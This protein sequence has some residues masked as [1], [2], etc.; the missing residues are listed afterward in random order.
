MN[1]TRSFCLHVATSVV[2]IVSALGWAAPAIASSPVGLYKWIVE[3][4]TTAEPG[5]L[6]Y[7][8]SKLSPVVKATI[9]YHLDA[10]DA[11]RKNYENLW[12]GQGKPIGMD[13]QASLPTFDGEYVAIRITPANKAVVATP[14]ENRVRANAVLRIWFDIAANNGFLGPIFVPLDSFNSIVAAF[15]N[16]KF[17]PKPLGA[18]EEPDVNVPSIHVFSEPDGQDQDLAYSK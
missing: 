6:Q 9:S 14:D 12:Y 4:S 1:R 17:Y 18:L 3:I 5:Y 8:G 16:Q 7:K 11:Q 10:Q 2:L 15:A 13:R